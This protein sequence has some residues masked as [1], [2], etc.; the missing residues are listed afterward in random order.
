M[1]LLEKRKEI[2]RNSARRIRRRRVEET[3]DLRRQVRGCHG[4]LN[5]AWQPSPLG[6]LTARVERAVRFRPRQQMLCRTASGVAEAML[7]CVQVAALRRE[8]GMLLGY[9][10]ALRQDKREMEICNALLAAENLRLTARLQSQTR[11]ALGSEQ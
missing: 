11:L 9:A 10:T 3:D 1:T 8:N 7:R 5:A 2:N 4:S 6:C